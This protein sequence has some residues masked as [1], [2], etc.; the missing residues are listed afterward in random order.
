M[1]FWSYIELNMQKACMVNNNVLIIVI[2]IIII[3]VKNSQLCKAGRDEKHYINLKTPKP[4]NQ[5]KK[6]R[7]MEN[8]ENTTRPDYD[9]KIGWLCP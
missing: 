8:S 6:V 9:D 1:E 7:N 5:P 4:Q 2:I 3:I